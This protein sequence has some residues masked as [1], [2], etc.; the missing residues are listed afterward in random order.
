MLE[1]FANV[2]RSDNVVTNRPQYQEEE[3]RNRSRQGTVI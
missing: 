1:N 3:S 2:G